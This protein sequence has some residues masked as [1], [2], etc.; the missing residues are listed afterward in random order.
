MSF[1]EAAMSV[2]GTLVA[3]KSTEEGRGG[4]ESAAVCAAVAGHRVA[5]SEVPNVAANGEIRM[6][7][8]PLV[9]EYKDT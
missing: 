8:T 3:M 4:R 9:L 7:P 6:S 1:R 5:G 2:V